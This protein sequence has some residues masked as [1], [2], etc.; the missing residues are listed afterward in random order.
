MEKRAV[1]GLS[2][3]TVGLHSTRTPSQSRNHKTRMEKKKINVKSHENNLTIFSPRFPFPLVEKNRFFSTR[4]PTAGEQ[5]LVIPQCPDKARAQGHVTFII[6]RLGVVHFFAAQ[7]GDTTVECRDNAMARADI[8][9]FDVFRH[10]QVRIDAAQKKLDK[11]V[12]RPAHR[13]KLEGLFLES[14]LGEPPDGASAEWIFGHGQSDGMVGGLR[15]IWERM[16]QKQK[17]ISPK[18]RPWTN[19]FYSQTSH[20]LTVTWLNFY[21]G[22]TLLILTFWIEQND[23]TQ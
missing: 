19:H 23:T 11:L 6:F 8:P 15:R 1:Q 13:D 2:R 21:S 18:E 16:T 5:T 7:T 20:I 12:A 10:V 3:C 17:F 9:L 22:A 14:G 4:S